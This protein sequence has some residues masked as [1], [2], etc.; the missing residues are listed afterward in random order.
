M[1]L[2]LM[3]FGDEP[4]QILDYAWSRDGKRIAVTRARFN[5]SDIV[6]FSGFR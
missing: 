1:P 3:H 4:T 5:D 2:R 6:L